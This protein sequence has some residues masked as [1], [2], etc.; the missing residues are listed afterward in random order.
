MFVS[1]RGIMVQSIPA[2]HPGFGTS[3]CGLCLFAVIVPPTHDPPP[4]TTACR[5]D[6]S[7]HQ[8]LYRAPSRSALAA[9]DG[10]ARVLRALEVLVAVHASVIIDDANA[11][12]D[13]GPIS[14]AV[15]ESTMQ[16]LL[17][18]RMNAT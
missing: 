16:W 1:Q 9:I 6:L 15:T 5:L 18:R 10:A 12:Y 3:P 8:G 2:G 17:H 14:T 13:D 11:H 4:G 7:Y